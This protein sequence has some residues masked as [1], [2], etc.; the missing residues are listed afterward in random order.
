MALSGNSLFFGEMGRMLSQRQKTSVLVVD[1]DPGMTETLADIFAMKGFDVRTAASGEDAIALA[2][3]RKIHFV[4]MDIKMPGM[5]GVQT[6]HALKKI[7]P[8]ATVILMTGY[9]MDD[10]I[11]ERLRTGACCV[12][13]KPL[14][15]DALLADVEKMTGDTPGPLSL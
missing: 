5:N 11:D 14:D 1:D 8:Q 4:L 6:M 10:L 3:E 7:Q 12:H 9:A 13:R 2:G 15:L